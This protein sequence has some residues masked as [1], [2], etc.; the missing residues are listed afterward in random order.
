MNGCRQVWVAR[1]VTVD[2]SLTAADCADSAVTPHHY[3]VARIQLV[4]NTVLTI[5]EHS[6]AINPSLALYRILNL[7]TYD[8]RWWLRTT[9]VPRA[10]KPRSSNSALHCRDRTT[11]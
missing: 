9:T 6:T 8:A 7:D 3:D 5:S 1:G 4:Q 2:D 11:S 10:I